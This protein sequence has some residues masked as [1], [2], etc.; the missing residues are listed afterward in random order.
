MP[1][2]IVLNNIPAGYAETS[3]R[4][5]ENVKTSQTG[6][7]SS[8]DGDDLI[9]RLEGFPQELI[10]LIPSN[11][12][13]LP[14]TIDTLMAIIR[15]D[16]KTSIYLN[17]VK[18][19]AEIKVK[20]A[21]KKGDIIYADS[22]LDFG[23]ISFQD[24][25]IPIDAGFIFVF[26]VGWRKG[27]FYDFSPLETN[28]SN[29][30]YNLE[31]TLGSLY[32]Y[33]MFQERFK[34]S[35]DIWDIMFAQ[36]WFP[37]TYLD[38]MLLRKIINHVKQGWDIDDLLPQ[39]KE[40]IIKLLNESKPFDKNTPFFSEHSEIIEHAIEKYKNDDF[41][42]CT[43]ILYPRIEGLMRSFYRSTGYKESPSPNSL[44]K[45]VIEHNQSKRISQSLLLPE[46]FSNYLKDVYFASFSPGSMPDVGR[47][48][49]AHGEARVDDFSLKSSSIAILVLYQLSLFLKEIPK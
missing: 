25:Q 5:G 21:M 4:N 48:S 26:S 24:I 45:A 46:K 36:K 41:I 17:E 3:A 23:P 35:Q 13:I 34:I 15:K 9:T 44:T 37:F 32:S 29:R 19:I 1:Y 33:L 2:E 7:F 39:I 49:V 43:S 28:E 6:F 11:N 14:S 30:T 10:A 20:R 12:P 40:N 22:I 47:H 16:K 27:F 18:V 38:D 31:E 42:S 8:E